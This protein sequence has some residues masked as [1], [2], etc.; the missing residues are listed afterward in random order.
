MI[1][2]TEVMVITLVVF[3]L[4]GASKVPEFARSL[5]EAK[6]EFE[7]GLGGD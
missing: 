6:R 3:L 2:T 4:F 7:K 5:G 1:G